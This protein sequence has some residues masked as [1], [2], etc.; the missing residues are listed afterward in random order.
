MW[1]SCDSPRLP[2]VMLR[3][4]SLDNDIVAT[5]YLCNSYNKHKTFQPRYLLNIAFIVLNVV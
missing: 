4:H 3:T 1:A 2:V 5:L